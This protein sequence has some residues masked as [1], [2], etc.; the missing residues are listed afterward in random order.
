MRKE[1]SR[2]NIR[3]KIE[4]QAEWRNGQAT[5]VTNDEGEEEEEEEVVMVV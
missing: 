5:V 1:S 2:N 3:A 4:E